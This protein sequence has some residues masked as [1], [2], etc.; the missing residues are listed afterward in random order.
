[1]KVL[2]KIPFTCF[3]IENSLGD[4]YHIFAPKMFKSGATLKR[5]VE[6]LGL[7]NLVDLTVYKSE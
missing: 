2:K 3:I 5:Y 1:M 4:S 7:K 6:S